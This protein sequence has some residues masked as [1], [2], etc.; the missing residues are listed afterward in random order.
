[1]NNGQAEKATRYEV[2]SSLL[3]NDLNTFKTNQSSQTIQPEM[4]MDNGDGKRNGYSRQ[5]NGNNNGSH[6]RN[7]QTNG[8]S[9]NGGGGSGSADGNGSNPNRNNNNSRR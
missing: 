9:T 7:H 2:F 4:D 1:M 3:S 8:S 6:R 5:Y